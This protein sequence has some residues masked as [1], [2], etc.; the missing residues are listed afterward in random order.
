[1]MKSTISSIARNVSLVGQNSFARYLR[2]LQDAI[3]VWSF[4]A[5]ESGRRFGSAF[6]QP[7]LQDARFHSTESPS[8]QTASRKA[9]YN[10]GTG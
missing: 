5:S 8:L 9:G 6:S 4:T 7:N 3:L 1:M 2:M 10:S